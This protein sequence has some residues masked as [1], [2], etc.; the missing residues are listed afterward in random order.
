MFLSRGPAA[1]YVVAWP[2]ED[3]LCINLTWYPTNNGVTATAY[4][5]TPNSQGRNEPQEHVKQFS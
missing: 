1:R 2:V 3:D 5:K 4:Q